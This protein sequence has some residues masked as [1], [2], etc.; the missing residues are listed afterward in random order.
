M[1]AARAFVLALTLVLAAPGIARAVSADE[2]VS[3]S[4]FVVDNFLARLAPDDAMRVYVQ[5]AYGVVIVPGLLQGGF[6]VGAEHGYGV[7]LVRDPMTGQFGPPTFIEVFAGSLGIQF[8]GKT[9][10][11]IMTVMNETAVERLLSGDVKLGAD[12]SIAVARLGAGIGAGVTSGFGEDIY[13]FEQAAGLFGGAALSGG[14]I[15][16]QRVMNEH[17]WGVSAAPAQVARN[18]QTQDGRSADLRT[19]LTMF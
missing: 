12:A 7:M 8:G 11:V 10:D 4:E 5:N 1:R 18:F 14:G 3:R 9:A 19:K 2:V 15:V 13:L 16:P 17:Y 6:F